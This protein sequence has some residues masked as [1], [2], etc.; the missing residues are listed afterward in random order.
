MTVMIL[1]IMTG[2]ATMIRPELVVLALKLV[3]SSVV[4]TA[5]KVMNIKIRIGIIIVGVVINGNVTHV[6]A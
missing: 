3:V 2:M 4:I 6:A 5:T 1:T